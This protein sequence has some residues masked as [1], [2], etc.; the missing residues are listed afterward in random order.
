MKCDDTNMDI[1]VDDNSV[2]VKYIVIVRDTRNKLY[3]DQYHVKG[4]PTLDKARD[5]VWWLWCQHF[6]R[7][8]NNINSYLCDIDPRHSYFRIVYK[9]GNIKDAFVKKINGSD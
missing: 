8:Q 4:Y 7:Q 1:D 3:K 6:A 2:I 9:D 5:Y